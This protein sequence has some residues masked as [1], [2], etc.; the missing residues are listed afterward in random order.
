MFTLEK[1]IAGLRVNL[2]IRPIAGG[3]I[4]HIHLTL[5][6][7]HAL[8]TRPQFT[9]TLHQAGGAR[10]VAS[11]DTPTLSV[12]K[13]KRFSKT[14]ICTGNMVDANW[15]LSAQLKKLMKI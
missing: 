11:F 9:I 10:A 8:R 4:Y 5:T 13:T 2:T 15:E 14:I 6:R 12:G 1:R 3:D 7:T